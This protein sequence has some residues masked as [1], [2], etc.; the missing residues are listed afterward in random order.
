MIVMVLRKNVD[1]LSV[2]SCWFNYAN[3]MATF[4]N[5]LFLNW[6]VFECCSWMTSWVCFENLLPVIQ[7]FSPFISTLVIFIL[8]VLYRPR[9]P[10]YKIDEKT[11]INHQDNPVNYNNSDIN[12]S[13]SQ[14]QQSYNTSNNDVIID[15]A[16]H[17]SSNN[18]GGINSSPS[19]IDNDSP[20]SQSSTDAMLPAENKSSSKKNI[21]ATD[22]FHMKQG[23]N[24]VEQFFIRCDWYSQPFFWGSI[25]ASF[26]FFFIGVGV[27]VQYGSKSKSLEGYAF[28][29]G[30]LASVLVF[31]QWIPQI[32]TTW[33]S[34][35]IGSL[36]LSSLCIQAPGALLVVYFQLDAKQNWSTWF[37]YLATAVQEIILIIICSYYIVR[38]KRKKKR[39]AALEQ[40]QAAQE[41]SEQI[42]SNIDHGVEPVGDKYNNGNNNIDSYNSNNNNNNN[43]D[44]IIINTDLEINRKSTGD[45]NNLNING[46]P[47]EEDNH[48]YFK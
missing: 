20:L 44:E 18:S 21:V 17:L 40:V 33:I 36:S 45:D 24:K 23:S 39:L 9:L 8:Y 13:V 11:K 10:P 7:M 1:G 41:Q 31:F 4:L 5:V 16:Q 15:D 22:S 32:Y 37:P 19:G 38:D 26:V 27:C 43:G 2:I 14:E 47:K 34:D 42:N 46:S 29:M 28:S 3:C 48:E 25:I 35:E 30:I 6:F 12:P